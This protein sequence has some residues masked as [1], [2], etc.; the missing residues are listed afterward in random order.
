MGL[1]CLDSM[2]YAMLTYCNVLAFNFMLLI[3]YTC[4]AEKKQLEEF[5]PEELKLH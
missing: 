3:Y 2:N 1:I 4:L 5:V